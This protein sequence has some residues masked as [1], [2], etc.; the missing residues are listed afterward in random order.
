[1]CN[2]DREVPG[3]TRRGVL[4]ALG[5]NKLDKLELDV[6]SQEGRSGVTV[7]TA[8]TPHQTLASSSCINSPSVQTG[9]CLCYRKAGSINVRSVSGSRLFCI[10]TGS[11]ATITSGVG[12]TYRRRHGRHA[13]FRPDCQPPCA[14]ALRDFL[15]T[16]RSRRSPQSLRADHWWESSCTFCAGDRTS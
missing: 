7:S 9:A 16:V 13:S 8:V 1:M 15:D 2:A 12:D 4:L 3:Q 10:A 14:C 5:M 11:T 6:E